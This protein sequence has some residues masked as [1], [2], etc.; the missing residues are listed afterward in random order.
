[1]DSGFG[2]LLAHGRDSRERFFMRISKRR[3]M[4]PLQK[5]EPL[6]VMF[7]INDMTVGGAE[8]LLFNL[9]RRLDRQRFAPEL[10]CMWKLGELGEQLSEEV[11][12][13]AHLIKHK[14]DVPVL[15]RL[16]RLLCERQIDAVVT[17]G[18][19]D[20]MFWGRLAAWRAQ[21][22]VV[23]SAIHSTGWPD[24]IER[25]NRM[26]TPLTDAF[27]GVAEQHARYLIDTDAFRPTKFM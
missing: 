13:F 2:Q 3:S 26:L 24:R 12:C 23:I 11:P 18:A 19:G 21:V 25:L 10:G 5:R 8:M 6:R 7:L 14:Y 27:V 17:V 1:M 16:K 22:P 9:I 20:R 4:L 15:F